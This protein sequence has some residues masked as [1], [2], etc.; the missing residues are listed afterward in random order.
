MEQKKQTTE[1][2]KTIY[3]LNP[4]S[5]NLRISTIV[6]M[7]QKVLN[8]NTSNQSHIIA[9][10]DIHPTNF[11]YSSFIGGDV[12]LGEGN[13]IENS[14]LIANGQ[15]IKFGRYNSL[16]N[17]EAH[18]SDLREVGV[19]WGDANFIAHRAIFHG[20]KG[21]SRN[22]FGLGV[23]VPDLA[24]IGDDNYFLH[25][26]TVGSGIKLREKSGYKGLYIDSHDSGFFG[27]S[28]NIL[29]FENQRTGE[30]INLGSL[31]HDD[32]F[33][34]MREEIV[35]RTKHLLAHKAIELGGYIQNKIGKQ[36]ANGVMIH[37]SLQAIEHYLGIAS[38][39]TEIFDH[40][41][42][43]ELTQLQM[44]HSSFIDGY[45]TTLRIQPE[46]I[47][48]SKYFL[49]LNSIW[50][51]RNKSY[52]K[53]KSLFL[54]ICSAMKGDSS[55]IKDKL[56]EI[57]PQKNKRFPD[58]QYS[59]RVLKIDYSIKEINSI[60]ITMRDLNTC[61]KNIDLVENLLKSHLKNT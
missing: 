34:F 3:F 5:K 55:D 14:I 57:P 29:Y 15:M 13:G 33:T 24:E 48:V 17:L 32:N 44:I 49:K 12:V 59:Q 58:F 25:G 4:G 43:E 9:F 1:L 22:Y 52:S 40:V 7:T 31:F 10:P 41:L 53:L 26:S 42:A 35:P 45:N 19:E 27:E 39:I 11:I 23:T 28:A 8:I 36:P 51:N 47:D 61:V 18:G 21:G 30:K 50:L 60:I 56:I 46:D 6:A 20:C 54:S 16:Q 2:S 38:K 37:H